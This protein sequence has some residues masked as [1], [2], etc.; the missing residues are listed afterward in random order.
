[1]LESGKENPEQGQFL[2]LGKVGRAFG[3][4]GEL[5][6]Y[7]YNP[8]SDSLEQIKTIYLGSSDNKEI[9]EVKIINLRRHKDFFLVQLEGIEDRT[10]AERFRN[11]KVLVNKDLL[12]AL[13]EGEYYWF[14]LIGLKVFLENEQE[15]G[16]VIRIEETNSQLGGNDILVVEHNGEEVMLPFC[17]TVIKKVEIEQKR[18]IVS[19]FENYKG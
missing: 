12:P 3:L 5:R 14:Q 18:I 17:A 10:Q 16:E 8:L 13:P 19:G 2:E 15:V 7:P 4:R 6:I 9:K 11:W 1:M